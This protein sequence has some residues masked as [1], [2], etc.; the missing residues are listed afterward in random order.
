[1]FWNKKPRFKIDVL[2][3]NK[4]VPIFEETTLLD[5]LQREG[6]SINSECGGMGI[7]GT[8]RVIVETGE[9]KPKNHLER[10]RSKDFEYK[11][12]ERLACQIPAVKNMKVSIP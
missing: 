9:L 10:E 3:I 6:I 4:P 7:C 11:E 5:A 2:G 12:N 1:M 8:C